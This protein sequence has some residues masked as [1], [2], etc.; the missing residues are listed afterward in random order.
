MPKSTSLGMPSG[1]T[2]ILL[3]LLSLTD[4]KAL[5]RILHGCSYILEQRDPLRRP[6]REVVAV[7]VDGLAFDQLHDK[8][9]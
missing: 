2:R 4:D 1:V 7:L 9:K 6:Q 3:G 5:M 8:V